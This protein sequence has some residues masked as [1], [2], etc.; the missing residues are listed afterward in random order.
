MLTGKKK[1]CCC[2]KEITTPEYIVLESGVTVCGS[3]SVQISRMYGMDVEE[4]QFRQKEGTQNDSMVGLASRTNVA[5]A[6]R[7]TPKEIKAQ[8]DRFVVGQEESKKMLA[9]AS[10]NH[11]KRVKMNDPTIKKSNVLLIGP[12]GCGKTYLVQSLARILAVPLA[13]VQATSMTE[14]GYIGDDVESAIQSLLSVCGG[15]KEKAERGIVFID[16]IDKLNSSSTSTGKVVGGKGVQQALL[17][18]LEGSYVSVPLSSSASE[19]AKFA[20]TVTVDTSNILFICGGAF[21]DLE[22]IVKKR[23][24]KKGGGLGFRPARNKEEAYDEKNLLQYVEVEDLVE[25]GMIPEILGRLPV[26]SQLE[27]LTEDTLKKILTEPEDSL[28]KQYRKLLAFDGIELS[29]EDE[30]LSCIAK[31]AYKE[32]TGARSLRAIMEKAMTEVMYEAPS[33]TEIKEIRI[34]GAYVKGEGSLLYF[35]PKRSAY[36]G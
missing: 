19:I 24:D 18:I 35:P 27:S 25:F 26:R 31:K 8:L 36:A 3:C 28:V 23:L 11:Y 14:A 9:I 32:G 20:P 15:D 6:G 12:T 16:E 7:I 5:R 21:P 4:L 34:T 22:G 33:M 10:Y 30:S 17:P 2:G 1:C 13:I 29:F